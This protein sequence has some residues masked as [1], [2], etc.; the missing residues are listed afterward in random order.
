MYMMYQTFNISLPKDL[1]TAMD[2]AAVSEYRNRSDLIREAVRKYLEDIQEWKAI[3]AYGKKKAKALNVRSEKDIYR[4][5]DE[6][7]KGK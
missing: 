7:R 1:V 3:Y 5:V 4:I 6:Y 2:A